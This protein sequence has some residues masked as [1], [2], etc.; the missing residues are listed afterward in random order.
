MWLMIGAILIFFMQVGFACLEVGSVA[1]KNTS[2]IL[3]KTVVGVSLCTVLFGTVGYGV[4]YG[5]SALTRL[6]GLDA[7]LL[8][9]SDFDDGVGYA[10]A[11][12]LFQWALASV[13]GS[14]VAGA[15][16]ERLT[17]AAFVVTTAC[18]AG[19][20]Y[21][22]V[23]GAVWSQRRAL[24]AS[25]GNGGGGESGENDDDAAGLFFG[26]G[27]L[28]Y[29]GSGVV[30]LTGGVAALVGCLV[31]GPRRAF[32]VNELDSAH[33]SH[34]RLFETLGTLVLWVGWYGLNAGSTL[35]LSG[36]G[37]V[38]AK[39]M[40]TTTL[41]AASG[42][43]SSLLLSTWLQGQEREEGDSKGLFQVRLEC[44]NKGARAGL[45]G[46]S[47]GCACVEPLGA[48]LTG[49]LAAPVHYFASELLVEYG[50]DDVV[51]AFPVH[52]AC[53]AWGLIAAAVFA[54]P[55]NYRDA[56][57]LA[58]GDGGSGDR[59]YD[60]AGV[61]YG[62][63]GAGLAANASAVLLIALWSGGCVL[64]VFIALGSCGSLRVSEEAEDASM[65]VFAPGQSKS[66]F[67]AGSGSPALD[68]DGPVNSPAPKKKKKGS[69]PQPT[70]TDGGFGRRT[71][72]PKKK[73][74]NESELTSS[75]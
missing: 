51:G 71:S 55:S 33:D 18:L 41:A 24:A 25:R 59:A 68:D 36:Y 11:S 61:A 6:V 27:V 23:A 46:I 43:L 13:V 75:V 52:G 16:C 73:K 4:A 1:T 42:A 45:V 44:L 2:S 56:Y 64:L 22:V 53:G 69:T 5:D 15:T 48:V 65:E 37:E 31:L 67:L 14:I 38:A 19:F 40:V 3:L 70:P 7:Y 17:T 66:P 8:R 26:C 20:V 32:L 30:H 74:K 49:C 29:A 21:P 35:R 10:Y 34:G 72:T 62:G 57:G 63:S 47:A 39:T 50:V 60:C 58:S 28:D 9:N 12:W 54:T